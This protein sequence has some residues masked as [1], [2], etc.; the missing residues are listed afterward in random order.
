MIIMVHLPSKYFM[1]GEL[2]DNVISLKD[3]VFNCFN[4]GNVTTTGASNTMVAGIAGGQTSSN[5]EWAPLIKCCY[6]V[7]SISRAAGSGTGYGIFGYDS[8]GNGDIEYCYYENAWSATRLGEDVED[9]Y[10]HFPGGT[11]TILSKL[12]TLSSSDPATYKQWKMNG[13]QLVLE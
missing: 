12:N 7:G 5:Q 1:I 3:N 6:S 10:Q 4:T 13:M 8:M 11:P 9:K 2:I